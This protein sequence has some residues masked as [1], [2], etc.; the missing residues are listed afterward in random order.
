M[1]AGE[2]VYRALLLLYP[3]KFRRAYG[4]QMMQLFGDQ[5]REHGRRAWLT[6]SRDLLVSL[7]VRYQEAI[8]V[9][10]PQAKLLTAAIVVTV[11]IVAF[12]AIGGGLVALALLL[13]LAWILYALIQE[14]GAAPRPGF[15]WK[16]TLCGV[17]IF[18]VV[19]GV[20]APPWPQSWRESVDGELAWWTG[21]FAVAIAIVCVVTGLLT[22]LLT[23]V[24][25][26][27]RI[28]S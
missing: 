5:R 22:G 18:A 10:N 6:V 28:S 12:A 27:R 23:L 21:F 9:M 13:G 25:S 19:F 17:G 15:W 1:S 20:F 11:G 16:L 2:R 24:H 3:P 4:A 7:P 26:R 14:R 8:H